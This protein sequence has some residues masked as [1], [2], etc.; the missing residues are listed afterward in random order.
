M[1]N[2]EQVKAL[3]DRRESD[4]AEDQK[5]PAEKRKNPKASLVS[6][7]VKDDLK[8]L[9]EEF[10]SEYGNSEEL[11]ARFQLYLLAASKVL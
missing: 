10:L 9:A 3:L 11:A 4:I 7:A 5:L 1:L 8:D 2:A 6:K